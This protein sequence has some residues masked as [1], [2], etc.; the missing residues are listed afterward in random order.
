MVTAILPSTYTAPVPSGVKPDLNYFLKFGQRHDDLAMPNT[1]V[2]DEVVKI[3]GFIE[4]EITF[5]Y[6]AYLRSKW[7]SGHYSRGN[8]YRFA[9]LDY[10]SC[11]DDHY[12]VPG[13]FDPKYFER[14]NV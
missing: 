5:D 2:S 12:E 4:P 10:G 1:A 11:Y 13:D 14:K 6:L 9:A 3:D 7:H 8:C